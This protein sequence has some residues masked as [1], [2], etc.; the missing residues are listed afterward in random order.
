M[1][2]LRPWA[3]RTSEEQRLL[4]PSFCSLLVWHCASG[5]LKAAQKPIRFELA[6][7]L[8]PIVLHREVR[9][10]LPPSVKTSI[11]VWINR[12]PS[13]VPKIADR[14]RLLSSFTKEAVLFGG[15][16]GLFAPSIATI[17]PI[18]SCAPK[19][20][21]I[22]KSLSEEVNLCLRRAEFVGK[23]YAKSGDVVTIL[24]LLGVRP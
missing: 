10:S 1:I 3:E 6:F 18:E 21:K 14:A 4:N 16:H 7:L 5:Y 9:D 17:L 23:W 12:N 24:A 20:K 2:L 13:L 22:E 19:I 8:L 15:K 11:P